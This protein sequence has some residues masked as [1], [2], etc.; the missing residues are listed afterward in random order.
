MQS[1]LQQKV[2]DA[3]YIEA[4]EVSHRASLPEICTL[5]FKRGFL[6][7]VTLANASVF[8]MHANTWEEK[9]I[10]VFYIEASQVN[11]P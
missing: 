4:S 1:H 8:D 5:F 6:V 9:C 10:D 11:L 2:I 7:A 3:F